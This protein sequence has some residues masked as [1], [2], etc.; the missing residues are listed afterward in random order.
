MA[1]DPSIS[2]GVKP[3]QVADPLAQYAQIAQLQGFQNQNQVAQ[4]Q[5]EKARQNERYLANMREAIINNGG[6]TD[7]EMAAKF[8]A[9]HPSDP[10]AQA[11]GLQMLQAQQE[12]KAFNSKYN[13][14]ARATGGFGG[15]APVP[16]GALGSGTYGITPPPMQAPAQA[17]INALAPQTAPA[18]V[19]N[20]LLDTNAL[21]QEL[22]D[23]S[24]YPNVP[25][26]KLRAGIIQ[27]QLEEASKAFVVPN[28]GLVRGSGETI[29]AS[30][31]APTD[32]KRL[33]A[34]RDALPVG[35]PN[36][37]LYDQAIADIGGSTRVAQQRLAFDQSK[38]AWE[39]A[40]PGYELKQAENGDFFGVNKRTLQAVPVTVG[41]AMP[42]TGASA[43]GG[44]L[45][46]TTDPRSLMAT[47]PTVGGGGIPSGRMGAPVVEG[48]PVAGT[49]FK[50]KHEGLKQIPANINLAII[51]NNQGVQQ[52]S[53]TIKLLEQNPEATGFKGFV[54][55]AILNRADPE[56][57]N[58]RAGVAD[59]GS[60]VMHERSGA[61]VTAS[62][63]PRLVP[64]IP[65]ITD[66]NA[67]A[68]KKLKRMKTI[69]EGEQK[70][71]TETYSKEQGYV[72]NPVV[73]KISAQ[74][75]TAPQM[76]PMYATNGKERIMS[77][78]G[79]QTW[80]PAK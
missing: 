52:L 4:M 41:G 69:I 38:F 29:V 9:T 80:T 39:K 35:D 5:L 8:M 61:A 71:L 25:Q 64:F 79:G 30:G 13:P 68:L 51:K 24:Q 48:T 21:R 67:T 23:L 1:V 66:D 12:L 63:S 46:A 59:I 42:S 74:G 62:E 3:L 65:L 32:I 17:P 10:N 7:M 43:V 14:P 20:A 44:R 22:F 55:G 50:G 27:K 26:A 31:M 54:P 73:S 56:G 47:E 70:G 19:K 78:D 72:P 77:T 28:V 36:R 33:T 37:K 34:E 2:L 76:P 11:A 40:N 53:D 58:A 75:E 6:P 15:G 16:S 49:P 57:V 60:L 45:N 18:P